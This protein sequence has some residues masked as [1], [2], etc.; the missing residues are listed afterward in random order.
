MN[1]K[2]KFQKLTNPP[3]LFLICL[4]TGLIFHF[5][6]LFILIGI[7]HLKIKFIF[8]FMN[9]LIGVIIS[10]VG[11]YLA[12]TVIK[13]MKKN[14][15][16]IDITKTVDSLIKEGPFKI[17]RNPI[18]LSLILSML[19]I[20]FFLSSIT[21]AFMTM[22]LFIL[23]DIRVIK[24]EEKLEKKFGKEYTEYKKKVRRWI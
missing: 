14:N 8:I 3:I 2:G 5:L 16:S 6:M 22:V 20:A 23:I 4:L 10:G 7:Y 9:I 17:T 12:I 1:N 19:G 11:G 21:I 15:N 24:E 13:I 18:Y